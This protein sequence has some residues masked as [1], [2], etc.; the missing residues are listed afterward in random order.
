MVFSCNDLAALETCRRRRSG[1]FA[2]S[3]R[4]IWR[5]PKKTSARYHTMV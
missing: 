3:L 1:E 5:G 4:V 2:R